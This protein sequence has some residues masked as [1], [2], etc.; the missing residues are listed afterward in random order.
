MPLRVEESIRESAAFKVVNYIQ[1]ALEYVYMQLTSSA[2]AHYSP[3]SLHHKRQ[4]V[5]A[6]PR[7][8]KKKRGW[9]NE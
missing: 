2:I 9:A 7:H 8:Q 6:L 1:A 5:S 3:V 4:S